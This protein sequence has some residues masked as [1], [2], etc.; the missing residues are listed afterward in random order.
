MPPDV[1]YQDYFDLI[2][3]GNSLKQKVLIKIISWIYKR[4]KQLES[5]M[6]KK[7]QNEYFSCY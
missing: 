3:F 7:W 1:N 6:E 4:Q 5:K 2:T